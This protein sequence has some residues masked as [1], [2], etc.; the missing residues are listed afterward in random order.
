M[1]FGHFHAELPAD[2]K[3]NALGVCKMTIDQ[4][5]E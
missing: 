1:W 4:S 5:Y 2:T 3:K